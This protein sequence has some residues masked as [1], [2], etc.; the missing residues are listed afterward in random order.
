MCAP[1]AVCVDDDLAA[2]QTGVTLGSADDEKT[3][4]LDVVDGLVVEELGGDD[5]LDDLLLDLLAQL[6]GGDV[7]A[8]LGRHDNGVDALGDH[9]AAVVCVLNSDLGLGVRAQPWDGAVLAGVG[10]GLVELVGKEEGK[11][12][13]L[14]GLVGGIAE[15]D[16]LVAGAQLL[17]SLLV[18]QALGDVGRLLLNGDEHVARLVVEALVGRVVADVLDGAAD[19]LL[20]VELGL[21][22]DLAKDHDHAGFRS[23]LACDL[24][25]RVLLEARIENGVRDLIAV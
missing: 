1:A 3:G 8:V 19:D 14:G 13:Q 6:L 24:G 7:L 20:V 10:H 9:G 25:E 21:G 16:A 23:R 18:V 2:G 15:H 5:L 12:K 4:R 11:G 22:C 17:E